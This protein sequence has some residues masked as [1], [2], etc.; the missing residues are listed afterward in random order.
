MQRYQRESGEQPQ[1][2]KKRPS[3][4]KARVINILV[5]VG[6]ILLLMIPTYFAIGSYVLE[7]NA[8]KDNTETYYTSVNVLGAGGSTVTVSPETEPALF[9]CFI[10]MLSSP[11]PVSAIEPGHTANYTVTFYTNTGYE[12]YTFHFSPT[13]SS[14]YFTNAGGSLFHVTNN[15]GDLFLNSSHAYEI[16]PQAAIPSLQAAST[17]IILPS[18]VAWRYRTPN[19]DFLDLQSAKTEPELKEYGIADNFVSFLFKNGQ[20]AALFTPD[21]CQLTITRNGT[22]IFD[23]PIKVDD[24]AIPLNLPE[25][26]GNEIFT[27]HAEYYQQ[28]D[29]PYYGSLV[30]RFTMS[31]TEPAA[32]AIQNGAT[33]TA[34]GFF[35]FTAQ[36]ADR[37]DQLIFSTESE[38]VESVIDPIVFKKNDTVYALIP[39]KMIGSDLSLTVR[40]GSKME[41]FALTRTPLAAGSAD[42]ILQGDLPNVDGLIAQKGASSTNLETTFTPQG[43]F[44]AQSG[45]PLLPFGSTLTTEDGMTALPF[46]L[47]AAAGDVTAMAFGR[48]KEVGNHASLGGYVI[49]DHGCG[50]YSWY[51][52]LSQ[53]YVSTGG[54]VAVGDRLGKAGGLLLG[55]NDAETVLLMTTIGKTAVDPAYLR[56]FSFQ[57]DN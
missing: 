35:L 5:T 47:Y 14:V 32:F 44:A 41:K 34:G 46:E 33:A 23:A 36:N 52:G 19:G 20:S 3:A 48:V 6:M 2:K 16:Y 37:I 25:L 12:R 13:D 50:I 38:A 18:E 7:K 39:A 45:A 57:F 53:I 55:P 29:V 42:G 8:P 9:Q 49:I 51:C 43:S 40:Y 56:S 24:L 21:D 54:I 22:E 11:N 31:S 28:S 27:I 26:L 30:Y 10:D 15:S 17:D 4:R 1:K